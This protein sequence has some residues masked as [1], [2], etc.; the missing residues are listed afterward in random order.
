MPADVRVA[1]VDD[2]ASAAAFASDVGG[3]GDDVVGV[4][5][6]WEPETDGPAAV[7]QVATRAA[8]YVVDL[9]GGEAL[10]VG[11]ALDACSAWGVG[12]RPLPDAWVAYAALNAYV[13]VLLHDSLADRGSD[14]VAALD[15][16]AAAPRAGD[17]SAVDDP[18]RTSALLGRGRQRVNHPKDDALTFVAGTDGALSGYDKRSGVVRLRDCSVFF[19]NWD[20]PKPNRRSRYFDRKYPNAMK[21]NGHGGLEVSWWPPRAFDE[22]RLDAEPLLLFGRRGKAEFLFLGKL[23][24]ARPLAEDDPTATPG[25]LVFELLDG[26][27]LLARAADDAHY[28]GLGALL[29][30]GMNAAAA[31][32]A[33]LIRAGATAIRRDPERS[34]AIRKSIRSE[35]TPSSAA[36]AGTGR[37][38]LGALV[39]AIFGCVLAFLRSRADPDPG[40]KASALEAP[41]LSEEPRASDAPDFAFLD[42]IRTKDFCILFVAFV[43]SSGPGLILI[44]NLGQIVPRLSAGALGD[45]LLAARGAPRPATLAFFCALTAAAMGLLAIG[46]PASLY[47]AVVVGGYA[48]GGL[49]GGIVPCYSEIWGFASFASL[50]SAGSLAEGAASYLMAT[51]LFGSLYQREIKSQGLAAS[52]TCVGRGCFLNAALV[53]AALAAFATLLCVVLAVRSRARYAALYP[54]FFRNGAIH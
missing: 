5:A 41:L 12:A 22:S 46:T 44:N 53:A 35:V 13:C 25:G 50:Y 42:A 28:P 39:A 21:R 3:R 48:Y 29:E 7:L 6:E 32:K 1:R 51:L 2:A 31:R 33:S 47:G 9:V 14:A 18:E 54:H 38:A 49:N 4:D 27:A 10:A 11:A 36:A 24:F 52:A 15:V 23:R 45:H 43:C 19:V 40:A 20:P 16:S 17:L 30:L 26:E 8:V 37:V 34:R